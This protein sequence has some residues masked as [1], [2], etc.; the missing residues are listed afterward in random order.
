MWPRPAGFPEIRHLFSEGRIESSGE[1]ARSGLDAA[2]AVASLGVDRGIESFS[3]LAILRRN[4]LAYLASAQGEFRVQSL[5]GAAL[6]QRVAVFL[7]AVEGAVRKDELGGEARA[8]ATRLIDSAFDVC[9]SERPLTEFLVAF[10]LL[11]LAVALSPKSELTFPHSLSGDWVG[12]SQDGSA[13]FAIALAIRPWLARKDEKDSARVLKTLSGS[14]DPLLNI[15]ALARD[16]ILNAEHLGKNERAPGEAKGRADR[17]PLR[18]AK[19][20]SSEHLNVLLAG[21][22][23]RARLTGLLWAM[24]LIPWARDPRVPDEGGFTAPSS[25]SLL[26]AVTSP[27]FAGEEGEHPSPRTVLAILARLEGRDLPAACDLASRRLRA[28]GA[29]LTAPIRP[30]DQIA[31]FPHFMAALVLP[32]P[33]QLERTIIEAVLSPSHT[34]NPASN[35]AETAR[36]TRNGGS[37]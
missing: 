29:Q 22:I 8:A 25:F 28:S 5:P 18:G 20:V 21:R 7:R 30:V 26:R 37:L 10:G 16:R 31:D 12:S 23:D 24:N 33:R 9:R 36:E 6:L 34:L 27:D 17:L 1:P 11:R 3:R 15:V 4:G 13:E 19:A 2:R 14:P 32:L 35:E